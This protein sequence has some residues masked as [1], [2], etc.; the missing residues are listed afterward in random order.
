LVPNDKEAC[1]TLLVVAPVKTG[2]SNAEPGAL[3]LV[4]INIKSIKK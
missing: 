4:K 2:P 1:A 3:Q